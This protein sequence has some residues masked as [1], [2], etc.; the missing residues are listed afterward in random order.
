MTLITFQFISSP[1]VFSIQSPETLEGVLVLATMDG[2]VDEP[3]EQV[4][5]SL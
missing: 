3:D 1:I 5:S 2:D 4:S